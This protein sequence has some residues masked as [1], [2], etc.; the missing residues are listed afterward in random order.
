MKQ[1]VSISA[2]LAVI[3]VAIFGCLYIFGLMSPENVLSNLIK[4][5][6]AI[7]LLGGCS[8]LV[9]FLTGSKKAPPDQE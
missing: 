5:L 7:V 6:A 8:A 2:V 9:V 3:S 4:V 1:I